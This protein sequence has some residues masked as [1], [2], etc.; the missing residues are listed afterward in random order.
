MVLDH[1]EQTVWL[2]ALD[3]PDA[4]EW[5]REA[6]AAVEAAVAAL[7]VAVSVSSGTVPEFVSRDSATDYKRKIADSQ[8]EIS[9]GNSYEICL[10]TTLEAP[11]ATWILGRVTSAFDAGTRHRSP[12]TFGSANWWSR[13]PRPSDSSAYCPTAACVRSRSREHAAGPPTPP[14]RTL[15]C[16]TILRR[17]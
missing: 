12:A 5:F 10:T 9:E 3:A 6:R 13:V 15:L 8:H 16:G 17:R 2:L 7:D 14:P 1:R 4:E 11:A